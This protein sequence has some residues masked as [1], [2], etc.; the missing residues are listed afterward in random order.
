[1]LLRQQLGRRHQ[2]HLITGLH[3]LQRR[4]RTDH[5]LAGADITL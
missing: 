5:G 2:R 3:R 1:M 4:Q